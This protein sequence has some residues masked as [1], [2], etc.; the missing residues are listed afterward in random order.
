MGNGAPHP[1]DAT[2]QGRLRA[3]LDP[4]LRA[5]EGGIQADDAAL[6]ALRAEPARAARSDA[7]VRERAGVG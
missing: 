5:F 1:Q 3:A 7:D 2:S 6:I 4:E